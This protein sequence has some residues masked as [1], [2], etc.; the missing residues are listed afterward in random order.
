M[1]PKAFGGFY[2]PLVSTQGLQWTRG[3]PAWYASSNKVRRGFCSDCGT[4]MVYDW[5][6]EPE[7]AIGTMD[8]PERARP[9]IQIGVGRRLSYVD[10]LSGL[11]PRPAGEDE[12]A[13]QFM[14]TI[15]SNQHP[16][17]DTEDWPTANRQA[18]K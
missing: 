7:I 3:E 12:A 15:I 10:G 1:C 5:G 13:D 8:D 4:P 11:P 16:D 14:A 9:T 18:T 17:H 2:A 6:G